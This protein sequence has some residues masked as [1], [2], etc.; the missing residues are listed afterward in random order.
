PD[1][2]RCKKVCTRRGV[3]GVSGVERRRDLR[4]RTDVDSRL[5]NH[6]RGC[7]PGPAVAAHELL[8]L[9]WNLDVHGDARRGIGAHGKQSNGLYETDLVAADPDRGAHA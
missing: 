8:I 3:H 7:E 1:L 4:A 2:E 6:A 9:A 5:T